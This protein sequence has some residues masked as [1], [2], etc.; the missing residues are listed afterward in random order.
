MDLPILVV[1]LERFFVVHD[2]L[3]VISEHV[4]RI[5][6]VIVGDRVFW[7]KLDSLL[8]GVDR[9]FVLLLEAHGVA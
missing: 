3:I 8:E 1:E 5:A 7:L 9:I 4:V 2:G 6:D